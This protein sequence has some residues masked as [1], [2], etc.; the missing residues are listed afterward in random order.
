MPIGSIFLG[1]RQNQPTT[2]IYKSSE[3]QFE[4][5]FKYSFQEEEDGNFL[6]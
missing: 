2:L 3:F 4:T 5:A 1:L 6:L